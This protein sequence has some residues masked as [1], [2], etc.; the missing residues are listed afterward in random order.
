M[1][2]TLNR[3]RAANDANE[4]QQHSEGYV[5]RVL[6][7]QAAKVSSDV[8]LFAAVGA[9]GVSLYL[10]M[11]NKKDDSHFIGQWAAPLMLI[12]VYNKLVK[13]AGSDRVH[14]DA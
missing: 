1:F 8:W 10:Q 14:H 13:L 4:A 11:Q 6:E 3:A 2:E 7:N 5:T 9:M 12:G